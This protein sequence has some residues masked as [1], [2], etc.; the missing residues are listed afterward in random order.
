M[1]QELTLQKLMARVR[2]EIRLKDNF[3]NLKTVFLHPLHVFCPWRLILGDST[4]QSEPLLETMLEIIVIDSLS[5]F[6]WL[7]LLFIQMKER[8]NKV[9]LYL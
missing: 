9:T 3:S 7:H 4:N 5:D 8:C 6:T 1:K 2:E